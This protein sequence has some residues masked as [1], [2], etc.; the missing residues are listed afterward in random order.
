MT[1]EITGHPPRGFVLMII[2]DDQVVF[3]QAVGDQT[4]SSSMPIAS[5]SKMPSSTL[6]A[7]L[8]DRGLIGLDDTVASY[9][10]FWPQSVADEKSRITIRQCLSCTSGLPFDDT[11]ESNGSLTMDQAVQGIAT[12][13]LDFSPGTQFGYTGNGFQVAGCVAEHVT[14][15]SWNQQVQEKWV[16]PLGLNV[17]TYGNTANP[18]LAGGVTT[19]A[20]DYA[21]IL[22]AHLAHGRYQGVR[23]FAARMVDRMQQD[24]FINQ[25]IS[26]VF[27]SPYP[28][29]DYHY[30]MGWWL[31][32]YTSTV[33]EVSDG[34][35]FGTMPWIDLTRG[36]AA[37]VLM[38]S[39]ATV[40]LRVWDNL[41]PVING[42]FDAQHDVILVRPATAVLMPDATTV[43]LS[44]RGGAWGPESA[45]NYSWSTVG[46]PGGAP[47]PIFTSNGN[48][49]AQECPVV[50]TRADTWT[51]RVNITST[52]V[53]GQRQTSDVTI[54]VP[55]VA[56]AV[57]IT[58]PSASV[59]VGGSVA[60]AATVLDQFDQPL[61]VQPMV[62]WST[63]AGSITT[64]GV[65]TAPG[66]VGP[67]TVTAT[68][69]SLFATC[70][71]TVTATNSAPV[72]DKPI[73][74]LFATVATAF[75]YT[76][77]ADTFS[78]ADGDVLTYTAVGMPAGVTFD[79][80]TCIFSGTPVS[81][82]VSVVTLTADDGHGHSA[83]VLFTI[84]VSDTTGETPLPSSP[85][86]S[87]GSGSSLAALLFFA[88]ITMPYVRPRRGDVSRRI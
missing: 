33:Q 46:M 54:M 50:I 62:V 58:P 25:G 52:A 70:T 88:V 6:I 5:A 82:G 47:A 28:S 57:T 17:F 81:S 3:E 13:P 16:G 56:T 67:L 18:R 23:L 51:F 34:G 78:D 12:L 2:K 74:A 85:G 60:L 36:Y 84:T 61:A 11:Y 72:L 31:S 38:R 30:G 64:S 24:E 45:I 29:D 7:D 44:A 35:A 26:I 68:A 66:V 71:V 1:A 32:P 8:I 76:C 39:T 43:T 65:L 79:A 22:S 48:N 63:S 77:A 40:G 21:R 19:N 27:N 15:K 20:D 80:S 59:V 69:G 4:L 53:P 83:T 42:V 14:G 86:V 10:S 55:M 73:P 9:L 87:C 41:R 75:V 49:D 37:V